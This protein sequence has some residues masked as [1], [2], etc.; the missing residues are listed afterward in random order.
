[1]TH[2][3]KRT[4]RPRWGDSHRLRSR[5]RTRLS[6]A[7]V[8]T[9]MLAVGVIPAVSHAQEADPTQVQGLSV[10]QQYGF[11][12]LAWSPVDGATDYQI[13]RTPIDG[14]NAATGPAVI[15][16]VW[17]PDRQVNNTSPTFADA[18]FAPGDRFQW[19]VRARVGTAAQPYSEPLFGT[20]AASW[21][22]PNVPGENL[23][24]QW[25]TTKS[26]QYSSDVDEYAYTA[27]LAELSERVRV[28]EI[29]RT[30]KDRPINMIA[31]GYPTPPATAAGIAA[32]S[33]LLVNCNVHGNEPGDREA[34]LIMARQ[35]AFSNDAR[36]I[37]LLSHTTVLFVPT[38]NG[39][40]RAATPGATRPART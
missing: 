19:R 1:M 39:D 11:A 35:L 12:T 21:G 18:G 38:I 33:P 28:I 15:T 6:I 30:V 8:L 23:R 16:G 4:I 34:C 32:T 13:E 10:T 24:T 20:T 25:E 31:L 2:E 29:G 17:R 5:G 14:A 40:G 9:T 3:A 7:A 37:D 36:T 27:A 26:V 22:D